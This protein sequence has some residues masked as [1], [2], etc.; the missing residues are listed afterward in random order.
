MRPSAFNLRVPMP[1]GD[2]FLMNTLTDAQLLVSDEVVALLDRIGPAAG[3]PD[4]PRDDEREAIDTLSAHG[5]VV[6]DE[7]AERAALEAHFEGF[8]EDA[9]DLRVTI[10][11]TLQCNFACEYCY[12]GD[13]G[14]GPAGEQ[15]SLETAALVARWIA[16]RV[17]QVR[18][19]RLV[20][21]FFGGEPL[22]NVSALTLIAEACLAHASARGV[23]QNLNVITNG[24]L[25]TPELVDRLLPLGLTGV[26]VTLDGDRDAHDRMRPLR[27]GQGTFDRIVENVGRVADKVPVAIGGNFDVSTAGSYPAL[28][29]FLRSQSFA[30]RLSTISFKPVIRP[31]APGAS[32]APR[33]ADGRALI[34]VTAVEDGQTALNGSCL[35]AAGAS[36][37]SACDACHFVDD[38]MAFLREETRRRGFATADGVHMG[39]CE[40]YRRHSHTIGPDG[41]IYACPGFTGDNALPIG[42]ISGRCDAVQADAAGRFDALAPWRQCGDCSFIPV[43]GGG[44]AV[45]AHAGL[46]DMD[47]PSCHKRAFE[48]ALIALAEDAAGA[49]TGRV[50]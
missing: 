48:S 10:L 18:P 31:S 11:T 21:T 43:C 19:S 27:G 39:P 8:R 44:C 13:R 47:A 49:A 26:K 36:S 38:Q 50:Q 24:L 29:D 34:P 2:V 5:F 40:L 30:P 37:G 7:A 22:L 42:H 32:P 17:D 4:V 16:R 3:G 9:S 33:T 6:S 28:L 46:G 1:D 15:M 23:A 45:A 20:L 14:T 35:S 12:Q 25:L 41:S